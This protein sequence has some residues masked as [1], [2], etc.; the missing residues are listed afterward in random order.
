MIPFYDR[1]T[2]TFTAGTQFKDITEMYAFDGDLKLLLME[3]L[4]LIEIDFKTKLINLLSIKYQTAHWFM[5]TSIFTS[6]MAYQ[7]SLKILQERVEKS[8]DTVFIKHYNEEY[9]DPVLPPSRMVF[10]ILPFGETTAIYQALTKPDKILIAKQYILRFSQFE[11]R[12]LCMS[13]L[14][15]LCAHS[16]RV[17]NRRMTRKV[18]IRGANKYF[19]GRID[20]LF[21]Y[22]VVICYLLRSIAP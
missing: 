19:Q 6:E 8:K 22:L 16:D 2:E 20:S 13:Y 18:N 14:R 11:S 17:W 5:N 12:M 10:Q 3:A 1:T 15:N 4:E 9:G 7:N 21:A